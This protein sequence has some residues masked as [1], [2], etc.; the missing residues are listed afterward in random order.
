RSGYEFYRKAL[1]DDSDNPRTY[2]VAPRAQIVRLEMYN[3]AEAITL[4]TLLR[5]EIPEAFTLA[6]KLAWRLIR[7]YQLPSG[8]WVTRIYGCGL[9]H[10]V[11]FLRWPQSQ[12]F[13]ALTNLLLAIRS[14]RDIVS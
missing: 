4:G 12:L 5:D 8:Y 9:K 11:P 1:F 13:L 2:A 7:Q 3:F 6:D 14:S 10:V